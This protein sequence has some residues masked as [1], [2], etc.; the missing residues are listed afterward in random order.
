MSIKAPLPFSLACMLSMAPAFAAETGPA[1]DKSTYTI[2][3]P[4]PPA[5]MREFNTD[6]P[7]K[8]ESPYTVDAG[9]FQTETDWITWLHDR[10]HE[11]GAGSPPTPSRS[12]RRIS[13]SA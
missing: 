10:T 2:F 4:T 5:L 13:R 7:D 3:N 11:A 12:F 8:T 9:H 6:R 1:P